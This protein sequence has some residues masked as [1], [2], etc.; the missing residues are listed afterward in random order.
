M[1]GACRF[2]TIL[3]NQDHS[4]LVSG[5]VEPATLRRR[6]GTLVAKNQVAVSHAVRLAMQERGLALVARVPARWCE[7][8]QNAVSPAKRRKSLLARRGTGKG[9]GE[10]RH[11]KRCHSP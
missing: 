3:A 5:N 9:S 4:K 11:A 1:V 6:I 7:D 8:Q 10:E 2:M